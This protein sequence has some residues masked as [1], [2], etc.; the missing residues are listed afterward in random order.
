MIISQ[1]I[2]ENDKN[3]IGKSLDSKKQI[4]SRSCIVKKI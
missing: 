2:K 3:N 4:K 1:D